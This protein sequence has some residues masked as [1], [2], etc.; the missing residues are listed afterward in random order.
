MKKILFLISVLG[1][2]QSCSMVNGITR[3][4]AEAKYYT[5]GYRR[6]EDLERELKQQK[7]NA[8]VSCVRDIQER[9]WCKINYYNN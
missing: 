7:R 2:A 5:L 9:E 1:M 8:N 3:T 4:A 6:A